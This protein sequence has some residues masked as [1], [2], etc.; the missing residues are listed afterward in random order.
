MESAVDGEVHS[1]DE[2]GVI[3][4]EK[5]DHSSDFVGRSS[6]ANRQTVTN[7]LQERLTFF[8]LSLSLSG[9]ESGRQS[10]P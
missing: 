2:A 8:E 1:I 9:S 5:G 4:C 3:G 6:P 7:R 10:M